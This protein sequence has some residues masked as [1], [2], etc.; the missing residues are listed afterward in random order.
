MYNSKK[1]VSEVS[2]MKQ[3]LSILLLLIGIAANV[4]AKNLEPIRVTDSRFQDFFIELQTGRFTLEMQNSI[5]I[6]FDE[7]EHA[8]EFDLNSE[9]LCAWRSNFS[10]GFI[11]FLVDD[12]SSIQSI[13]VRREIDSENP[14]VVDAALAIVLKNLGLSTSDFIKL[15]EQNS[16]VR[17]LWC[18]NSDRKIF[19][20]SNGFCTSITASKN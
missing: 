19:V 12:S 14:R 9:N 18:A 7:P 6:E 11:I 1:I 13:L 5:P 20:T 15:S 4:Q 3:I 17:D 2:Y 16:A 8:P 10:D